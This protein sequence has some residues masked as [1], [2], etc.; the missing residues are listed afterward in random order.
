MHGARASVDGM[1]FVQYNVALHELILCIFDLK[2][3]PSHLPLSEP[4]IHRAPPQSIP[5]AA[6]GT[7]APAAAAPVTRSRCGQE[8]VELLSKSVRN[9]GKIYLKCCMS[10]IDVSELSLV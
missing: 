9:P 1:V 2:L 10:E 7:W 8:V 5:A 3:I 6:R 4:T